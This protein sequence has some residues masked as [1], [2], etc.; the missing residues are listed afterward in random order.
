MAHM[1]DDDETQINGIV[2][3][4]YG[5]DSKPK[6]T[7]AERDVWWA[8]C[9]ALNAMPVRITAFH[10]CYQGG[11]MKPLVGLVAWGLSPI[12]RCRIQAVCGKSIHPCMP[13]CIHVW[14]L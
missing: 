8:T 10:Y 7:K 14:M 4:G 3:V 5:V 6:G 1:E 13:T 12:T 9:K 11:L 2:Y